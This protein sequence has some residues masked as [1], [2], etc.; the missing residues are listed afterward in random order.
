MDHWSYYTD[1]DEPTKKESP[2]DAPQTQSMMGMERTSADFR[3]PHPTVAAAISNAPD[4]PSWADLEPHPENARPP[5]R[6]D[7]PAAKFSFAPM[8]HGSLSLIH[9]SEPTRPY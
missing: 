5:P 1:D 2:C 4:D 7:P 3:K 6:M 9:I 8:P